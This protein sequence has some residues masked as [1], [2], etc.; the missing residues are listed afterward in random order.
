MGEGGQSHAPATLPPAKT[1][2]PLYR[3]LGR[4]HGR[5]G[6][7]RKILPPPGLDPRTVQSVTSGCTDWA[8]PAHYSILVVRFKVLA[9]L[10]LKITVVWDMKLCLVHSTNVS[11]EP[12][13]AIFN[14]HNFF[15]EDRRYR[16]SCTLTAQAAGSC[17][18]MWLF[19]KAIFKFTYWKHI[20]RVTSN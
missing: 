17:E 20:L 12:T 10:I 3:K 8:I 1:R 18:I 4:A 16:I 6:R 9:A 14:L 15:P 13:A 5:S 11:D 2:Q 7:E 19:K